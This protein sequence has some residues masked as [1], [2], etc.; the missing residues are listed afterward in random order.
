[1]PADRR[2]ALVV[3]DWDGTLCDSASTIADCIQDAARDLGL[4]VPDRERAS[5]VI[6][7]GLH[8]SLRHAVPDLP[9]ER[10][11][12]FVERY[13]QLFL[14]RE[15]RMGLFEGV[16]DLLDELQGRGHLLAVATGKS[17]RG[18]DRA[19]ETSGLRRRFVASRC[20]DETAPKP[21]PDMLHELMRELDVPAE[22]MVMIG[23]T[24]H[25]LGMASSAGV[26]AV[27]VTYG[28]HP[29]GALRALAPRGCVSSVEELRAWLA[30]NA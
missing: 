8:D 16:H 5:H 28:A 27:A 7:L 24:S 23:D 13:R 10:Y 14:D 15:P 9:R 18:L 20:A 11:G 21:A 25:D 3:F 2:Y 6:G 30:T 4:V 12:E 19:F 1:M 22:A 17:R 29:A 26:D